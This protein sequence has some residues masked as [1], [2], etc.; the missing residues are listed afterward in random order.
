[1]KLNSEGNPERTCM[2][3]KPQCQ[4]LELHENNSEEQIDRDSYILFVCVCALF[5]ETEKYVRCFGK[6]LLRDV[7]TI[8]GYGFPPPLDTDA[9]TQTRVLSKGDGS[10][11][12]KLPAAPYFR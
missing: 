7:E 10:D 9:E 2:N 6:V 1:M 8:W 3:K 11:L 5:N 4:E 12:I